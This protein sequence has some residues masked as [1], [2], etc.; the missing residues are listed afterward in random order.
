[1]WRAEGITSE[2]ELYWIAI[3]GLA[4]ISYYVILVGSTTIK[5]LKIRMVPKR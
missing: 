3:G 5:L 1:M 4:V 2:V